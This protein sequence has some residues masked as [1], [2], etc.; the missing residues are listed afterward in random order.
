MS[1]TPRDPEEVTAAGAPAHAEIAAATRMG[2]VPL[3][4]SDLERSLAYYESVVG[5]KVHER[6]GGRALLGADGEDLLVLI[7]QPGARPS[8]GY[9]GLY[10]FALLLPERADLARWLA[11]PPRDRVASF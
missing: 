5:V 9:C 8:R 2:A 6:G 4:V 7:E 3:T 11:H 1:T 10:H